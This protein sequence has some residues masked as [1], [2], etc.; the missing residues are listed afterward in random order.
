MPLEP[1]LPTKRH[2]YVPETYLSSFCAEDGKLT[3]FRK[4]DPSSPFRT[5]PV[6]VAVEGYYYAYT[7]EDGGR[8]TDSFEEFFSRAEA[9][10][11]GYLAAIEAR[12]V[13]R[14]QLQ[15]IL[16][17]VAL[18]RG[19]VP[20]NRDA[21]EIFHADSSL[22][23]LRLMQ[24][25]GTLP[26]PPKGHEDILDKVGIAIDPEIS[27]K[28]ID[29]ALSACEKIFSTLEFSVLRN[30]TDCEFLTSD[31][32]VV[33][34]DPSSKDDCLRPYFVRQNGPIELLFPLTP[35]AVLYGS[36]QWN[37]SDDGLLA[38]CKLTE[39]NK[40]KRINKMI[41]RFAYRA[42]FSRDD[43]HRKLIEKYADRS[44]T[45]LIEG[46]PMKSGRLILGTSVFGE[47]RKKVKW[48]D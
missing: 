20:A 43:Q 39:R 21:Y 36:K 8:D 25:R 45:L 32:P 27:L 41:S 6:N 4:D 26:P 13:H 14:D 22:Q 7:R 29:A 15:K 1:K 24:E 38:Y 16:E 37:G 48:D 44:P 47:R 2:H 42:V 18:Q 11:P 35:R 3:V 34:Y 12:E 9:D 31:N 10:W 17:F 40:A 5:T 23:T 28:A 33:W 19:R 30:E 46:V